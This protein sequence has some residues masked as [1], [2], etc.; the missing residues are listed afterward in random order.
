MFSELIGFVP[1]NEIRERAASTVVLLTSLS[2]TYLQTTVSFDSELEL[3]YTE[4]GDGQGEFRQNRV[5]R[6]SVLA[7]FCPPSLVTGP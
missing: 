7:V 4:N 2:S 3:G 6:S 5:G 1:T